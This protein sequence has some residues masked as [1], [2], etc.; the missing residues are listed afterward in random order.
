MEINKLKQYEN[1]A[2]MHPEYQIK[3]IAESIKKFGFN[4]PI[5]IWGEENLIIEGH[6]RYLACLQL[7]LKEVDVIRLDHLTENERKA[8]TLTHN[9]LNL[10]TGFDF[11]ILDK[12]LLNLIEEFDMEEFGFETNFLQDNIPY[13]EK[14]TEINLDKFGDEEFENECPKCKF[15]FN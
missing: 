13:E 5:A 3:Q 7:D 8:Y 15:K 2:K 11:E 9:K 12:E 4:D 6:G 10:N 14:E 1:N